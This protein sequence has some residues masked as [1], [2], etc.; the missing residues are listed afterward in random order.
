MLLTKVQRRNNWGRSRKQ[1]SHPYFYTPGQENRH[2]QYAKA[3]LGLYYLF[4]KHIPG[5][6][7]HLQTVVCHPLSVHTSSDMQRSIFM[8]AGS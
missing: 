8:G 4:I 5:T 6:R 1:P 2:R 3:Y 7:F